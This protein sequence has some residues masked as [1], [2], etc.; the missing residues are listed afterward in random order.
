MRLFL[1]G[2]KAVTDTVDGFDLIRPAKFFAQAL[3]V[4][5]QGA[6]VQQ[7]TAPHP[8]VQYIAVQRRPA[9]AHELLQQVELPRGQLHRLALPGHGA[10]HNIHRYI[11]GGQG[12]AAAAGAA[13]YGFHTG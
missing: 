10:G 6:A 9:V 2:F 7:I 11:K 4:Q 13:Q 8:P 12:L 3:D 5:V 1:V